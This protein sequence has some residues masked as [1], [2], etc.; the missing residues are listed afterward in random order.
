MR[1]AA[2]VFQGDSNSPVPNRAN[3]V[4]L[5][6]TRTTASI[7]PDDAGPVQS[8]RQPSQNSSL[9]FQQQNSQQDGG[10]SVSTEENTSLGQAQVE[11]STWQSVLRSP[12]EARRRS[13]IPGRIVL[14]RR[15]ASV[16]R[17]GSGL[18]PFLNDKRSGS[19][20]FLVPREGDEGGEVEKEEE[21]EEEEEEEK[22][23][24]GLSQ[25]LNEMI[26]IQRLAEE[27]PRKMLERNVITL[28]ED[29]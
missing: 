6:S 19:L 27:P 20:C 26:F 12:V 29:D 5:L 18:Q 28:L 15:S 14:T 2:Y 13:S 10:S 7:P 3:T 11:A 16:E 23:L 1:D 17:G 4:N 25:Q 24:G 21:E 8:P 22:M 9:S